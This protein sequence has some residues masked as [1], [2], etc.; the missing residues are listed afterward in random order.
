MGNEVAFHLSGG[1]FFNLMLAARKKPVANQNQ[2]LERI[3]VHL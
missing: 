1:V 2:C 3:A